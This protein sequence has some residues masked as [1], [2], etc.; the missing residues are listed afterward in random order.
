[1]EKVTVLLLV[2]GITCFFLLV[3]LIFSIMIFFKDLQKKI[4]LLRASDKCIIDM[5]IMPSF[6]IKELLV[7]V[8][9]EGQ[10]VYKEGLYNTN[11]KLYCFRGKFAVQMHVFGN[12]NPLDLHNVGLEGIK[13]NSENQKKLFAQKIIRDLISENK[14]LIYILVATI[15]SIAL[16]MFNMMIQLKIIKIGTPA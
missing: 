7:E 2:L 4:K 6:A 11:P 9:D 10:F 16:G 14:M 1:M 3:S 8:D 12:P 15:V 5:M 13:I